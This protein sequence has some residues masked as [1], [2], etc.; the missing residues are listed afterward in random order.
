VVAIANMT[1]APGD[2][3]LA[4]WNIH[5]GHHRHDIA[6]IVAVLRE[7]AADVVALQEVMPL[8]I[9]EGL[10]QAARDQLGM[11]VVTGRTFTRRNVD[12]GNALL[13]RFAVRRSAPIDLTVERCEPRNAIDAQIVLP[14]HE[15]RVVATHLGLRPGE[16][17][18]QVRRI[19]RALDHTPLGPAVVMG[20]LNEWYLWGRPLRWLH[21]RFAAMRTP[22][23]FPAFRPVLKLDRIWGHPAS[24]LVRLATHRTALARSASD[25]LPLVADFRF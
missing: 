19:L 15:L 24:A 3:R 8:G 16:R 4:T 1:P 17:R 20:D 14:G 6:R 2:V 25:H 11:H 13:S 22:A 5:G 7:M 10:L 18:E 12:Y 21:R 9:E 23:T